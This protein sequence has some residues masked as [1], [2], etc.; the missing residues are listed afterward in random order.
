M[1]PDDPLSWLQAALLTLL[2]LMSIDCASAADLQ[3]GYGW[4]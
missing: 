1:K 3:D 2:I 4:L